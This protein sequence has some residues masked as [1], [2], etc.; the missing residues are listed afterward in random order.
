[1]QESKN[2]K[3]ALDNAL[4][5]INNNRLN[6][7]ST[8]GGTDP[9]SASKSSQDII[10]NSYKE[11][12]FKKNKNVIIIRAGILLVEEI[13]NYQGFCL[14]YLTQFIEIKKLFLEIH[15]L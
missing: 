12:F 10:A 8:L 4:E 3:I 9:Y 6:E 7:N 13:G 15:G 2:L 11:S 5:H 1:M 14:I